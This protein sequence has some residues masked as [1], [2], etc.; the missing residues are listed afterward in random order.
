MALLAGLERANEGRVNPGQG[1]LLKGGVA[2]KLRLYTKASTA[3][4]ILD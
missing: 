4:S 1:L 2:M 3:H